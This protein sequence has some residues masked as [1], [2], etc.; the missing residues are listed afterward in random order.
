MDGIVDGEIDE[1]MPGNVEP[2]FIHPGIGPSSNPLIVHL[3]RI[4]GF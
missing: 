3:A 2:V 4:A 1:P